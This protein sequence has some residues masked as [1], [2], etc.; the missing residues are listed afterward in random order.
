[1]DQ[2]SSIQDFDEAG[3]VFG[4]TRMQF[5]TLDSEIAQRPS[6]YNELRI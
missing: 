5:E 4:C 3:S 6:E 1:M 2:S